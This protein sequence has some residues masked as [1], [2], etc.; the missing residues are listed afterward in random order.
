MVMHSLGS[1]CAFYSPVFQ[2]HYLC[3][4]TS[5]VASFSFIT[6]DISH[7]RNTGETPNRRYLGMK[8]EKFH[9]LNVRKAFGRVLMTCAHVHANVTCT[10]FGINE[11]VVA[12]GSSSELFNQYLGA[13]DH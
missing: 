9:N 4:C 6:A 11:T 8:Y 3:S 1:I 13:G 12:E 7:E 2:T 5:D 10:T